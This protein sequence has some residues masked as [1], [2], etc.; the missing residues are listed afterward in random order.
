MMRKRTESAHPSFVVLSTT[1]LM[2]AMSSVLALRVSQSSVVSMKVC[3]VVHTAL[4]VLHSFSVSERLPKSSSG[5]LNIFWYF[6]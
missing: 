4:R 6:W 2:V 5:M 1:S 3:R